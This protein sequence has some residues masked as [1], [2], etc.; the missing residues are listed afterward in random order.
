MWCYLTSRHACGGASSTGPKELVGGHPL[1]LMPGCKV[2]REGGGG[3]VCVRGCIKK[4]VR[5]CVRGCIRGGGRV[6]RCERVYQWVN[7]RVY[8]VCI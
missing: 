5:G 4:V 1:T 2:K 3:S 7:D 8:E 6:R